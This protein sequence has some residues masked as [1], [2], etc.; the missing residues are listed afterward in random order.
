[1]DSEIASLKPNVKTIGKVINPAISPTK[2]S[3]DATPKLSV[4]VASLDTLVGLM[5]G[6]ITFPIV[7]TFGLSD[8]IS[9]ST[10]GALF[11]SIPTGLGSY[12][13]VGR[14]V[15]VAFFSLAYIAAI[16]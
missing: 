7:L 8:A 5:A 4:G 16:T 6:L 12:G 11:I 15:A 13:A 14:I 9:E 2:V 3:N 10:V 1:M